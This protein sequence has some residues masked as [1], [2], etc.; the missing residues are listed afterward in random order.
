M[1]TTSKNPTASSRSEHEHQLAQQ[2]L[3]RGP[4]IPHWLPRDHRWSA[5]PP[6]IRQNILR[7]LAPAYQQIVTEA[8]N[9]IERSVGA[10]FVHLMWLEMCDQAKM[11]TAVADPTGL[12]AVLQNPNE[13]IDRHLRLVGVKCKTA[14]LLIKIQSLRQTVEGR[15]AS[16]EPVLP[17][18]T[19]RRVPPS[20]R[21]SEPEIGKN[22]DLL[23]NSL[24]S[25]QS[26][27]VPK[28]QSTSKLE[29]ERFDDQLT[30]QSPAAGSPRKPNDGRN[31]KNDG[32]DDQ[33][34]QQSPAADSPRKP[35]DGRNWKN[36]G[37]DDQLTQQS[38]AADSPR[39]PNDGRNW[40]NDGFDDRLTQQSP[41]AGSPRKPN[42]GR[43][44]KNDGF[45]DQL[46]QQS[47]AAGSPRKPNDGRNWKNDGFDDQLT[48]HSPAA[49]L[50]KK[51][52]GG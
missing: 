34:T 27:S 36:D 50:P 17:P 44:W 19:E 5:I 4:E 40:K 25:R 43:N 14:A 24:E 48:Q 46:T 47:P 10:T 37:F 9:E 26:P 11:A 3:E 33:L 39:K 8:P 12:D 16:T 2:P 30:L 38:P 7:I 29:N 22:D 13:M 18:S 21:P 6:D 49:A 31:W 32:F 42:D 23:I 35:N 41:A 28:S 45:D 52:N 15:T 20:S 1:S 51:P